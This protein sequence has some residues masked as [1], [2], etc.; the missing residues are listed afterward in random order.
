[1]SELINWMLL[2]SKNRK[3][4]RIVGVIFTVMPIIFSYTGGFAHDWNSSYMILSMDWF[5]E[6]FQFF[7]LLMLL[8]GIVLFATS[9]I[10]DDK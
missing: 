7:M 10:N 9:F 5:K 8:F 2:N 3:I 1:M 4:V 6:V